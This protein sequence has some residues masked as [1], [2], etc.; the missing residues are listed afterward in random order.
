MYVEGNVI[1]LE[2]SV[3]IREFSKDVLKCL[4]I[5]GVILILTNKNIFLTNKNIYFF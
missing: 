3:E 4:P 2:H 5:D 1:L